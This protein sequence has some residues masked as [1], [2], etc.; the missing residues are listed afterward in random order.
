MC[1]PSGSDVTGHAD[2]WFF[3]YPCVSGHEGEGVL[4]DVGLGDGVELGG[5]VPVTG[6]CVLVWV[7]VAVFVASAV[8]VASFDWSTEPSLP[9]LR[10]RTEMF[11]LLGFT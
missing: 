3:Q 11:E 4:V 1:E 5:G 6:V 10:T 7:G 9:G 8:E 2:A